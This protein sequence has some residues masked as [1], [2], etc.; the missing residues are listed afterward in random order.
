MIVKAIEGY[1]LHHIYDLIILKFKKRLISMIL[2][3]TAFY[4]FIFFTYIGIKYLRTN[5]Y[6]NLKLNE[7]F[8]KI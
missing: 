1:P 2:W 6:K 5:F 7:F 8:K 4:F 3:N